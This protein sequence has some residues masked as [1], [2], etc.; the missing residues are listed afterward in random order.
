MANSVYPRTRPRQ[1][2]GIRRLPCRGTRNAQQRLGSMDESGNG[3]P[4][5]LAEA[6]ERYQK[7]AAQG[8]RRAQLILAWRYRSGRGASKDA[9]PACA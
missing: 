6:L 7:A 9:V 2:R 4:E 5:D 1:W 3:V 8:D